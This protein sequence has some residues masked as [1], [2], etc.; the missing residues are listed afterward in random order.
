MPHPAAQPGEPRSPE[1]RV[2]RTTRRAYVDEQELPLTTQL[3]DLL[4][5]FLEHRG[6]A[7]SFEEL[8]VAVWAYQPDV[9]DHHFL[10]TAVYRLRRILS[11]VGV[12]DLIAGIRGYGYRVKPDHTRRVETTAEPTIA[13]AVFDPLDPELPITMANDAAVQL[14]GHSVATLTNRSDVAGRLWDADERAALDA[15]IWEALDLGQSTIRAQRLTRAD[16]TVVR[17]DVSLSRLDLSGRGPLCLAEIRPLAGQSL[18]NRY[19]HT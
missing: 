16:G 5:F 11:D 8:A 18:Q 14:T 9:G 13:I 1:L 10:H 4:A 2:D 19:Q 15:T 3:F 12:D 6:L 7:I 17:V